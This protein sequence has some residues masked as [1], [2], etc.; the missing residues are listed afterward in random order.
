MNPVSPKDTNMPRYRPTGKLA[1]TLAQAEAEII[2][3]LR[4]EQEAKRARRAAVA[5]ANLA[6]ARTAGITRNQPPRLR[7]PEHSAG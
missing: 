2:A 6:K 5:R 7:A 3:E 4:A 1:T